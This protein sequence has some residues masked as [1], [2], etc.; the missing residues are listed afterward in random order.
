VGV[1]GIAGPGG[2]TEQKPVGT[3]AI[4]VAAAGGSRSRLFRFHGERDQV[5]FQ[6]SQAAMDMVRRGLLE[7]AGP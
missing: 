4:A 6:A 5:K 3:V 1:T 7:H 2:G